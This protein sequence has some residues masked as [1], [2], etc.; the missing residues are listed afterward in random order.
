MF[1]FV[2]LLLASPLVLSAPA[3]IGFGDA[4]DEE[5]AQ[6]RAGTYLETFDDNPQYTFNYKVADDVEQTYMAMNEDRS[7]D[8]VTGSYQYV[9]PYGSLIIVNYSAGPM[10]YSETREV[11]EGFVTITEK[12]TSS[13]SSSGSTGSSFSSGSSFNGAS[14]GSSFNGASTGSSF[15]GA[16]TG[17]SFNGGSSSF[18]SGSSLSSGQSSQGSSFNT[19]DIVSAVVSQVQPLIPQTV[20]SAVAGSTGNRVSSNQVTSSTSN[21]AA[22]SNSGATSF[23]ADDIISSVVSQVQPLISQTVSSAVAGST[24]NSGSRRTTVAGSGRTSG[25]RF[26]SRPIAVSAGASGPRTSSN[27]AGAASSRIASNAAGAASSRIASSSSS[28][29]LTGLFGNS[30]EFSVRIN[31]PTHQIEY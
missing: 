21:Q 25:S 20:S 9:D 7:G 15:N 3:Q 14:T 30:G 29:S 23:N 4:T 19:N 26:S 22:T 11:R 27:T 24:R 12:Q 18:T 1:Q 10:G 16:S 6:I 31:T 2:L 28:G 13:S 8:Q 17:S 5:I